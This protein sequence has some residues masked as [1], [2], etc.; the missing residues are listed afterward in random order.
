M[1][2]KPALT[3]LLL[4]GT[5]LLA[6]CGDGGTGTGP[7]ERAANGE[8]GG[9]SAS[10]RDTAARGPQAEGVQVQ[11]PR[12]GAARCYVDSVNREDLDELVGCFGSDGVVVDVSRRIE[13]RE[14]IREWAD[15]E[16]IGG[17]LRVIESETRSGGVRLLV[18]WAPAG[19]DGWRAYYTFEVRDGEIAIADLQYA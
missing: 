18:H 7:S 17:S 16:V 2:A 3:I 8:G 4:L 11:G 15:S 9:P 13:G 12:A 6:A 5:L 19:S 10:G 14:A 1:R